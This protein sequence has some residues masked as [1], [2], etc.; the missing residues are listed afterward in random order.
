LLGNWRFASVGALSGA[1]LGVIAN[2]VV[3]YIETNKTSLAF[4]LG[5]TIL[6]PAAGLVVPLN[7]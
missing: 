4:L 6:G 5:F 7:P 3:A 2:L 1:I